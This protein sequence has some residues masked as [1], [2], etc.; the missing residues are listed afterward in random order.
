MMPVA[1]PPL[2]V[3][4]DWD[5]RFFSRKIARLNR[6]ALDDPAAS[7][8]EAQCA[9]QG[10]EWLYFIARSDDPTTAVVAQRHGYL[11]VDLRLTFTRPTEPL[12]PAPSVP[13][14]RA[15]AEDL[16][17]LRAIARGAHTDT[18]YYFDPRV[19]RERCDALYERWVEASLEGF[20]DAVLVT[21]APGQ[22]TGY[23]T[24]KLDRA[25]K[26]GNI[27]LIATAPDARGKG[28][29]RALVEGA[30]RWMAEQGATTMNVVTQGRNV[31]AQ[32]L[33]QRAGYV[34]ADLS[35]YYHRWFTPE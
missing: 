33:Y 29:G 27:G 8:V 15:T 4:L 26:T 19:P 23:V 30:I 25:A 10:I 12:P 35:L 17:V 28:L 13:V 20:A 2:C 24:C 5:C 1:T 21:G 18:R 9:A 6:D 3:P 31:V 16:P 34:T 7:G 22:P 11:L 32:R 14:R